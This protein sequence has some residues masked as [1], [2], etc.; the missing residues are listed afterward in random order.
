[1]EIEFD[2]RHI[3][4]SKE[5]TVYDRLAL[6]FS[7]TMDEY[8]ARFVFVSGYVAI[9]FGRSRTSEDVDVLVERL[10]FED[11]SL[12]WNSLSNVF[13]CLN[14]SNAKSAY[15]DYL[16]KKLAVRFSERDSVIPNIEF[17]WG[18]SAQHR[19]AL[20]ECLTVHL[21]E[22]AFPISSFEIQIAFKL[23]LGSDKDIEDARYLFELFRERLDLEKLNLEITNLD[24]PLERA[25]RDLGW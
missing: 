8:G 4:L 13:Y 6:E 14:A 21:N 5:L 25:M 10:P 18:L 17:K 19:R 23:Y 9:L 3:Y 22:G 12:L 2:D 11:F 1:M 7:R 16:E 15:Y 24:V 20:T